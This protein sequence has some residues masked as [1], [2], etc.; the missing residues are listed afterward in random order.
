MAHPE[1]GDA[2]LLAKVEEPFQTGEVEIIPSRL[3]IKPDAE[4]LA[5]R[6]FAADRSVERRRPERRIEDVDAVFDRVDDEVLHDLP[7]FLAPALHLVIGGKTVTVEPLVD[8]QTLF[9]QSKRLHLQRKDRAAGRFR[10]PSAA[11][12]LAVEVEPDRIRSGGRAGRNHHRHPEAAPLARQNPETVRTLQLVEPV[13]IES[14]N[15]AQ[16]IFIR[17]VRRKHHRNR[18][19]QADPNIEIRLKRHPVDARLIRTERHLKGVTLS[20]RRDSGFDR[21]RVQLSLIWKNLLQRR[22]K[23]QFKHVAFLPCWPAN[24]S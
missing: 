1:P 9:R 6:P 23:F 10:Q 15:R 13:G 19:D 24:I 17:L 4:Q 2:M 14:G 8:E 11:V 22:K 3:R 7:V 12:L 20:P 16:H 18:F 5:G 21:L